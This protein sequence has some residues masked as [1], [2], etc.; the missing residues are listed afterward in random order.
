MEGISSES[1]VL[2]EVVVLLEYRKTPKLRRLFKYKLAQQE[3]S[4]EPVEEVIVTLLGEV[5]LKKELNSSFP[6][7]ELW[8][9]GEL[10]LHTIIDALSLKSGRWI[11]REQILDMFQ[12]YQIGGVRSLQQLNSW[13]E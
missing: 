1:E 3:I 5:P 4:P 2:L 7:V 13:Y 11:Q 6:I 10:S 9:G 12:K 8:I